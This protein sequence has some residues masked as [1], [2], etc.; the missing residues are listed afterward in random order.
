[1]R[2]VLVITDGVS[3][4]FN[5]P[6]YK[7]IEKAREF[8]ALVENKDALFQIF[9][10]MEH[11]EIDV[12]I[13]EENAQDVL[14]GSTIISKIYSIG[15]NTTTTIGVIGPKRMNYGSSIEAII[16]VV[17]TI[18]QILKDKDKGANQ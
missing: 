2:D 1:M 6:E 17:H 18:D 9:R 10:A 12:R 16:S 8:I 4:I 15:D 7:D 14:L 3:N 13:G 5:Y 11:G